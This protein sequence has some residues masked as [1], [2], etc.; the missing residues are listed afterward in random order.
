MENKAKKTVEE[1][2][3]TIIRALYREGNP[4]KAVLASLRSTTTLTGHRAQAIWPIMLANLEEGMLSKTGQPTYAE[5]AVFTALRFYAI[6]QQGVEGHMVYGSAK[7]KD[8][9]DK[10]I[11]LFKALAQLR[12]QEG[13][14]VALDRRVRAVLETTNIT[15]MINSLSHLVSILKSHNRGQKIDYAALA[16]DLYNAQWG[17]RQANQVHLYWGQQYYWNG[18]T[19]NEGKKN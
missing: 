1:T 8:E 14:Q 13:Q 12:S 10:G 4:N 2:T 17:N 11:A 19:T 15:G 3:D 18:S 16:Q 7:A 6:Q 9:D 5:T